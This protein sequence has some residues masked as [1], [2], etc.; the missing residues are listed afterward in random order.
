MGNIIDSIKHRYTTGD[1]LTKYIL[2]NVGVFLAIQVIGVITTL[3]NLYAFDIITFLGVPSMTHILLIRPWTPFTYMFV[4]ENLLH[5][6]FNMLWLYWFGRMFLENFSGRTFGSLYI[7]GGLCGALFYAI[8]FNTIPYYIEMGRGWMIGASAAVMA[9]VMGIAFYRPDIQVNLLLIGRVKIIHIAI[10]AFVIDFL[11]LSDPT[12]PGGHIA[13]IGG[14]VLGY[15][16]AKQYAKGKDITRWM[17]RCIDTVVGWFKPS[18][19]KAK[20]KTTYQRP[21]GEWSYQ[22][23]SENQTT[24]ID[25]ILDKLKHSGYSGL[26]PDEKKQLFDAS[27]K[28]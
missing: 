16:F 17:S 26:T 10:F 6:F 25:R 7:L 2:I 28:E 20:M 5:L 14:A 3:F 15:F 9:I 12:N 1:V 27:K 8:A 23:K 24:E 18:P 4:H 13:H 11:Q 21:S 22:E 19:K